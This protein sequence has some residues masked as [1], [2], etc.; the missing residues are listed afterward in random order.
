ML[1]S[2]RAP[3]KSFKLPPSGYQIKC[4]RPPF[5]PLPGPCSCENYVC[6]F[7]WG[8]YQRQDVDGS[9]AEHSP[10][11]AHLN[12]LLCLHQNHAAIQCMLHDRTALDFVTTAQGQLQ[13]GHGHNLISSKVVWRRAVAQ[14]RPLMSTAYSNDT[15][16]ISMHAILLLL[17]LLLLR[18][19]TVIAVPV[20][21]FALLII[22][23]ACTLA[24]ACTF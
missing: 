8:Q 20:L 16:T 3:P 19:T 15:T 9:Q 5:Q 12:L 7:F 18:S 1:N 13:L 14:C 21:S 2:P 23:L 10:R 24:P 11:P 22:L 4:I 17:W 6:C